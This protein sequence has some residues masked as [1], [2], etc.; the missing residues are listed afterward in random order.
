MVQTRNPERARGALQRLEREEERALV[1]LQYAVIEAGDELC[2]LDDVRAWVRVHPRLALGAGTA[3]GVLLAPAVAAALRGALPLVLS[4][5]RPGVRL[6]EIAELLSG[7][8][9]ARN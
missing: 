5:A 1:E 3:L 4:M 6:A 2:A 9:R 8:G 7:E